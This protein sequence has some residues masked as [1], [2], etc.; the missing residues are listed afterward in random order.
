MKKLIWFICLL[1]L[2]CFCTSAEVNGTLIL[3]FVENPLLGSKDSGHMA[4]AEAQIYALVSAYG[5]N[6]A[7]FEF[8]N[9]GSENASL[10]GIY[11]RGGGLISFASLIDSDDGTGGDAGVDFSPNA[12]PPAPPT[13]LNWTSFFTTDSDP[14]VFINGVNNGDPTGEKLGIIFDIIQTPDVQD[15]DDVFAALES[16]YLEIAIKVWVFGTDSESSEWLVSNSVPEPTDSDGDGIPDTNDNCPQTFNPA[17]SDIDS[18]GAGDVCDICPNDPLD[19]CDPN[20]SGAVIIDPNEGG[21]LETPNGDLVIVIDPNDLSSPV[22]ISITE[23]LPGDP[24]AN[25]MIGPNPG[26]GKAVAVYSFDPNGLVFDSPVTVTITADVTHLNDEQRDRLGLY[27]WDDIKDKFVHME[28]ADCNT[29]EDP[30]G[31][32]IKTCT[33]ELEHFSTYAMLLP[34]YWSTLDIGDLTSEGLIDTADLSIMTD[35]WLQADSI[36]DIY[37]PPPD[38]DNIV[39]ILDFAVLALHWLEGTP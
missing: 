1:V 31:T 3:N 36:A 34:T 25:I 17:Q 30:P 35:D 21:T 8:H 4:I 27:L 23:I 18:D 16:R 32:F 2:I 22:T 28:T 6:Q 10:T 19:V 33:L 26:D 9:D 29:I 24:N 38:G 5:T 39:N 11:F 7:L 15:I 12:T 20:G 37:P 14:S 13:P